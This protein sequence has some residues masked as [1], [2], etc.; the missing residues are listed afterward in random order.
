MLKLGDLNPGC[1]KTGKRL[2]IVAIIQSYSDLRQAAELIGARI[3]QL[4]PK[5]L[6][7]TWRIALLNLYRYAALN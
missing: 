4:G 7:S 3:L 5:L 1:I 6:A 2:V